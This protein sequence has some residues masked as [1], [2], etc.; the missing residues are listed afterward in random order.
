MLLLAAGVVP[1]AEGCAK[2]APKG[3]TVAG[4]VVSQ[5]EPL[6][7]DPALANAAAAYVRVGFVRLG[8]DGK[9]V[10][11]SSSVPAAVDGSFTVSRLA[12]GRYRVT[13]EHFNG[14]SNDLLKGRFLDMNSPIELDVSSD[15]PSLQVDLAEF[16]KT[17]PRKP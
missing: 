14:G 17:K 13:V 12:A 11:S 15:V 9:S 2:P 3:F 16:A 6:P 5:G 7:L 4:R 8:E 1:A 10:L